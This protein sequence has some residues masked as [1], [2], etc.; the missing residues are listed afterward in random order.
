MDA[1]SAFSPFCTMNAAVRSTSGSW[2]PQERAAR[3]AFGCVMQAA[4]VANR[5]RA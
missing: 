3:L 5:S 4:E 2:L 1:G